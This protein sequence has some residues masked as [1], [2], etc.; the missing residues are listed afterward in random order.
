MG[1]QQLNVRELKEHWKY[2]DA[3]NEGDTVDRYISTDKMPPWDEICSRL[4]W[5]LYRA[6]GGYFSRKRLGFCGVY[7]LIGLAAENDV[8]RPATINR[9]C[10]QDASGTLYVGEAGSLNQRLNQFRRSLGIREDSHGASRMYRQSAPLQ[11]MFP[12]NKLAVAVFFTSRYL[13]TAVEHDLMRAYLNT[14]GD[15]PP[16]NCS[17]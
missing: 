10:G 12:T 2:L 16:L 1:E 3:L 11:S 5:T 4:R 17:Y 9:V 8:R 15:T 14:F 7:R 13:S 6:D